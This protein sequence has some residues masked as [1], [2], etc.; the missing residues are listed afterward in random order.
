MTVSAPRQNWF[1][2]FVSS[3]L[4]LPISAILLPLGLIL[5]VVVLAWS[6]IDIQHSAFWTGIGGIS[7]LLILFSAVASVLGLRKLECIPPGE[8]RCVLIYNRYLVGTGYALLVCT[9]L[10]GVL[11]AGLIYS[12][13]LHCTGPE[14]NSAMNPGTASTSVPTSSSP[15]TGGN[16]AAIPRASEGDKTT[17]EPKLA[18]VVETPD[19]AA[20]K[21]VRL[22]T[23]LLLSIGTAIVGALFFVANS[24]R[25]KCAVAEPFSAARFWGGLWYRLGEA[26]LF[27]LVMFWLVWRSA[28]PKH[29]S[30]PMNYTWLPI[31]SLFL[32]MFVKSGE[33]LVFAI[34]H[35]L[36]E[37]VRGFFGLA[38][39]RDKPAPKA[40]QGKD[41]SS[42]A[43]ENGSGKGANVVTGETGGSAVPLTD[44]QLTP[45]PAPNPPGGASNTPDPAPDKDDRNG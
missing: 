29:D 10:C 7:V 31:V 11:V 44:A 2:Q 43:G 42:P 24:L 45:A 34:A 1:H 9:V 39:V 27:T 30:T 5:F 36:F 3:R 33:S 35:G 17:Q 19:S 14:F 38:L 37:A 32:G 4:W 13:S 15:A 26:A 23:L 18:S 28:D 21:R 6:A 20:I 16:S 8:D 22:A 12:S 41:K 25:V 40:G